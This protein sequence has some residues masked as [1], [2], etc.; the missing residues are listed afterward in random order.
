MPASVSASATSLL[1][2][3]RSASAASASAASASRARRPSR[4]TPRRRRGPPRAAWRGT[5]RRTAAPPPPLAAPPPAASCAGARRARARLRSREP[6]QSTL[7]CGPPG[8]AR[9]LRSRLARRRLGGARLRGRPR[10]TA[11][12]LPPPRPRGRPPAAAPRPAGCRGRPPPPPRRR[13]A[14]R[15]QPLGGTRRRTPPSPSRT[16]ERSSISRNRACRK[17]PEQLDNEGLDGE[18]GVA[19]AA[20]ER[21]GDDGIAGA[22]EQERSLSTIAAR[23]NGQSARRGRMNAIPPH[24]KSPPHMLALLH[25]CAAV[26]SP[27]RGAAALVLEP[28]LRCCLRCL[29]L[30]HRCR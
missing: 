20:P 4:Q 27:P 7:R 30:R 14:G 8:V 2:A 13:P 28:A 23:W 16:I 1:D 10:S 12:R 3:S 25:I 22:Q 15:R 18:R 21:L 24:V 17:L 11:R 19:A 29:R 9:K 6:G 5:S 26:R